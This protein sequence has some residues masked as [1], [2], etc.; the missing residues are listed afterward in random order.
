M[1]EEY[2]YT[3]HTIIRLVLDN[4]ELERRLYLTEN[5]VKIVE[6][7]KK[8]LI[9]EINRLRHLLNKKGV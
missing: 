4:A 7:E 5:R 2:E 9:K 3:R 1:E 8:E 6:N